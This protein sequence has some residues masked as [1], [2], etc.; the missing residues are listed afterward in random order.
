[1]LRSTRGRITGVLA[2]AAIVALVVAVPTLLIRIASWPLPASMPDWERVRRAVVQGDVPADVVV[3]LLA[4]VVWLI[5]LQFVWALLWELAVNVPRLSTGRRSRPAPLVPSPVGSGAAR[6]V[7][8]ALTIGAVAVSNSASAS[9]LPLPSPGAFVPATVAHVEPAVPVHAVNATPDVERPRWRVERADSLWHVAEAA[10][11]DGERVDEILERNPWLGSPRHLRAGQVLVLP[12]GATVPDDRTV[13]PARAR[14]DARASDGYVPPV[15]VTI[16]SGDTLWQLAEERLEL[17]DDDVTDSETHVY[18]NEVIAANA[19]VVDDPNLIYPGEVFT[20][21]A[22]GTPTP[23]VETEDPVEP[24]VVT[25]EAPPVAAEPTPQPVIEPIIDA[26]AGPSSTTNPSVVAEQPATVNAPPRSTALNTTAPVDTDTGATLRRSEQSSSVP[27]LAGITGATALASSILLAYRRRLAVRAARGAAAYR[28]SA[29]DDPGPLTAVTRASD[30]SLLRWA[31]SALVD[32]F[33]RLTPAD[34]QGQ[35]LAVELSETTGIEL[36]WTHPNPTAPDPWQSVSDG[37]A[38]HLPYDPDQPVDNSDHPAAIPA[39]VTIGRRDGNQLLLNLEAVGT[40]AV[41]GDDQ[42]ASDLVRSI[43]V[44]LAVG[45]VLT[46]A[47]LVAAGIHLDGIGAVERVQCRDREIAR[48]ALVA[49]VEASRTFLR[50]H[51]LDTAFAARLGGDAAGRDTTIVAVDDEYAA[52]LHNDVHPGLAACLVYT[53]STTGGTCVRIR[54]DGA[55]VL[56]P[57]GIE[58]EPAAFPVATVEAVSDLLDEASEPYTP[59]PVPANIEDD[60]CDEQDN[61]VDDLGEEDDA[62]ELPDPDVL[63]RVLGAPEVMGVTLGR[64]ETSIVTYLACHGGTRRDDQVINAVWNGRAVEPKTL[65]NRISKIRAVL[66]P[67]LVPPRMPNS[68]NVVVSDRVMTDLAILARVHER[69]E[70]VSEAEALQLLLHGLDLIHGVPFDSSE[71]DWSFETQDHAA[72]CELV[73]TASL[74]CIDI[75]MNLDDLSAARRAVSQGL[76]ALPMNE[77]LYRARMRIEAAS[78]NPEGVRQALTALTAA[79]ND[80]GDHDGLAEP[81]RETV[82]VAKTL[83]GS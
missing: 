20:F 56:E 17:V 33:R 66:G 53:G 81:A 4:V 34:I 72:A 23:P 60:S 21:P 8:L 52:P 64:I 27:W 75:A 37:W 70:H 13:Q 1:M 62:W 51:A 69:A 42:S 9:A 2:L 36:L 15:E 29:Q 67:D 31:N 58:F 54:V 38:W 40:L 10:L 83:A 12:S 77:P 7:A 3:K 39:L 68:P 26:D 48:T 43:V 59:Q 78:G 50:D 80:H 45:E 57:Q 35:P 24:P 19:D 71:Y 16:E 82:R 11:G 22:V 44:E 25:A 6:L 18:V 73:E 74:R 61:L 55:A 49:A 14:A 63:V 41:D 5:W 47:Y 76:R 28:A 32:V 79:L 65:W 46:D 30:V